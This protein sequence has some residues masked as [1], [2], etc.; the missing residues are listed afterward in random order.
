[1][2][3]LSFFILAYVAV[4]LQIGLAGHLRVGSALPNFPLFAVAFIAI[5]APR[6]AGLL[7]CF[8]IG[9]ML[10]LVTAD[11]MGLYA[12]SFGLF[13]FF[14]TGSAQSVQRGHPLTHA[15]ITLL[16]GVITAILVYLHGAIAIFHGV[17]VGFFSLIGSALY[18][19]LLAPIVLWALNQF[20]DVFAFQAVRRRRM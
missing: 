17:H 18:T 10:D 1:L 14:A 5:N 3:W 4:G 16:G 11:A 2:R 8:L 13:A 19:A 15:A 7:G 9:L 12:L 6:E 20:R